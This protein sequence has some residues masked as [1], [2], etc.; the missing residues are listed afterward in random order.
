MH[1][2][3]MFFTKIRT[4]KGGHSSTFLHCLTIAGHLF[5]RVAFIDTTGVR[6]E[7][8]HTAFIMII[9]PFAFHRYYHFFC[10]GVIRNP[11]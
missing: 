4:L 10:V 2:P 5:N 9:D 8:V 1:H 11:T 6:A 7:G 3:C